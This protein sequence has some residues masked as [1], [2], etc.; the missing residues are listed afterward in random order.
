MSAQV[1]RSTFYLLGCESCGRWEEPP[2]RFRCDVA[3]SSS[4]PM[5]CDTCRDVL[6]LV[7]CF[8][9][10][11]SEM[12][13]ERPGAEWQHVAYPESLPDRRGRQLWTTA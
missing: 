5:R 7:E 2:A 6:T 9:A 13:Q 12:W 10:P 1:Q 8:I 3:R 4:E 11:E